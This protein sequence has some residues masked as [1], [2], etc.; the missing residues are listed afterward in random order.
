[1]AHSVTFD[2]FLELVR[3]FIRDFKKLNRLLSEEE[4]HKPLLALCAQLTIDE[5]IYLA[6]ING[7][8]INFENFPSLWLLM[9]GTASKAFLSSILLRVRNSMPAQGEG[10]FADPE[11]LS[12]YLSVY[13]LLAN[14]YRTAAKE[15]K[16]SLDE[17]LAATMYDGARGPANIYEL[18]MGYVPD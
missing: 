15:A 12:G 8:P 1:M 14:Q 18:V 10:V 2:Q 6:P 4:N 17:K 5:Y 13:Q 7:R 9:L 11:N 16:G 3:I